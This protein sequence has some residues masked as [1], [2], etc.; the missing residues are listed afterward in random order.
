MVSIN[1]ARN[2]LATLDNT[3]CLLNFKL[4]I[5]Y[6]AKAKSDCKAHDS[7]VHYVANTFNQKSSLLSSQ[8]VR[9]CKVYIF[10]IAI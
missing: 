8:D 1:R 9:F 10:Y 3:Y 5:L 6:N 7:H 4:S 2:C